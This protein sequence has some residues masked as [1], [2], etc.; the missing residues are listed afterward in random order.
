[1]SAKEIIYRRR[2]TRAFLNKAIPNKDLVEVLETTNRTPSWTNSQPWE[3]FVVSGSRLENL[4]KVWH[5]EASKFTV[6][7]MPFDRMDIQFPGYDSWGHAPQAIENMVGFKKKFAKDT[8]L[9]EEE[10]MKIALENNANFFNAPTII[11]LGMKKDLGPYSMF[12]M[13]AY[14]QTLMLAAEDKGLQTCP[15]GAFV[16]LGDVLRKEL[17]IPED[18]S[19][20]LGIA[21]GYEDKEH[22]LN[23]RGPMQR[24]KLEQYVRY[25][26]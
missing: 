1:M 4:K 14:Q 2:A 25:I 24:M 10:F 20:A 16:I 11:Y 12:D 7:T 9:S 18:I 6:E 21:I 26:D 22:I 17:D 19:V 5:S 23:K 8:G 3:V 13:G 15:A